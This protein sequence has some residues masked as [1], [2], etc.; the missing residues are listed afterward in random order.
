VEFEGTFMA[1]NL[2]GSVPTGGL[3][4]SDVAQYEADMNS[5]FFMLNGSFAL[6]L[7]RYRARIGKVLAGFRPYVG[8]GLGGGQVWYRNASALSAS[9]LSGGAVA[10]SSTP[11][12]IDEFINAWNWYAGVEWTWQDR[13]SV[14]ME[15]RDFHFGD[16][17][18]MTGYSTDGYLVGFRYRY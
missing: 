14:F 9:Q 13:Y 2:Q 11:F 8:A 4:A 17:D 5:L 18:D 6:D 3:A 12:S 16:L 1:T 15:Y 7:Y 10:P